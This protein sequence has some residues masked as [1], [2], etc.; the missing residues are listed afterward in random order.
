L[1]EVPVLPPDSYAG[2]VYLYYAMQAPRERPLGYS[3]AAPQKAFRTA[4]KLPGIAQELGVTVVVEYVDGAPRG[5][6]SP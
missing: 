2:S 5:L 4:G 3:T 1:L 6:T